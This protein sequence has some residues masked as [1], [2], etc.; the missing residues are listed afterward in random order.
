MIGPV[1][2]CFGDPA[3]YFA[4]TVRWCRAM[5]WVAVPFFGHDGDQPATLPRP[6]R[7]AEVLSLAGSWGHRVYAPGWEPECRCAC[8]CEGCLCADAYVSLVGHRHSVLWLGS[9]LLL[10]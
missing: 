2:F 5:V 1:V 10:R 3:G 7:C 8:W 4:V 6:W 9:S